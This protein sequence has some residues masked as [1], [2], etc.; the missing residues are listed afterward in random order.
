VGQDS[1]GIEGCYAIQTKKRTGVPI[2]FEKMKVLR[3]AMVSGRKE[4]HFGLKPPE[5]VVMDSLLTPNSREFSA[6][7]SEETE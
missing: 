7:E 5:Q 2:L 4:Q 1:A 6:P 3:L